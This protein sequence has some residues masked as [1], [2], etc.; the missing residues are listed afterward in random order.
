MNRNKIPS[1]TT[2]LF[3]LTMLAAGLI[4]VSAVPASP[5]I[6]VV[7]E[8][9]IN[10]TLTPGS[11]YTVSVYT[12]YNENNDVWA[13]QFGLTYNPAVLSGTG[14]VNGDLITT[15]KDPSAIYSPGTFD[16]IKGRLSLTSA[17]FDP[18]YYYPPV[19]KTTGGPGTLAYVS[20]NVIGYGTSD[21]VLI[22]EEIELTRATGSA[23]EPIID[24]VV[25]WQQIGNSYFRNGLTGDANLDKTINVFDILAV[26]SR[27]GRTPASGDWIREY[28]VND[29][30]AINVFDILTV[31][32]NWGQTAP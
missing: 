31:K 16:N 17:F 12:D 26:K 19:Y 27:W 6:M 15:T 1:T 25:D 18:D 28:D 13:W 32:A 29:D 24:G 5:Y 30:Q 22:N 4:R 2:L 20:F 9:T 8:T 3:A 11:T 7:P 14:V 23:T 10:P 21:I